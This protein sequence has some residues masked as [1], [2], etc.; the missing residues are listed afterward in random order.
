MS[1]SSNVTCPPPRLEFR[2]DHRDGRRGEKMLLKNRIFLDR[3]EGVGR[4]ARG[5]DRA[6]VDRP[7]PTRERRSVRRSQGGSVPQVRRGRLRRAD[8]EER[9]QPRSLLGSFDGAPPVGAHPP[10]MPRSDAGQGAGE[11][12][13]IR[14]YILPDKKAVYT[15]IEAT[16]QHFKLIMEGAKIPA[17]ETY[18]YTEG[19]NGELGLLPRV[20]RQR[21]AVPRSHSTALLPDHRRPLEAHRGEHAERYRS[22]LRLA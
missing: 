20:R 21:H 13:T 6:L 18:S 12:P 16:I 14:G 10:A 11:R 9:R 22:D 1:P 17:G 4:S 2:E 15:T 5:C 8:R 19:G 3:L 7:V